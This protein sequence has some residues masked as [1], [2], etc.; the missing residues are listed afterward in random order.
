MSVI[1]VNNLSKSYR[2]Y[3]SRWAR[4]MEWVIPFTGKLHKEK[5]VLKNISFKIE[6]GESVGVIGINGAGKST[7]LKII[8]GIMRPTAGEIRHDGR[9]S[10]ILELGMGFHPDFTGRQ[11]V[12][13]A[14]QL[15]GLEIKELD[16]LLPEIVEFSEIGSYIDQPVRVYSSGMQVRL[17]FGVATAK[18]PGILIVDEAFSVGDVAFQRKCFRRIEEFRKQGTTL[19]LVSH[20]IA[21]IRKICKKALYIKDGCLAEFGDSRSVC[22]AYEKQL[23]SSGKENV[24]LGKNDIVNEI[25]DTSIEHERHPETGYGDG[26]AIIENVWLVAAEGK[27]T[28][29]LYQSESVFRVGLGVFFR[30]DIEDVVFSIMIKTREGLPIY[31]TDTY[32][33]KRSVLKFRRDDRIQVSFVLKNCLAP[34]IYYLNCAVREGEGGGTIFVHRKIDTLIFRVMPDEHTTSGSGMVD[35]RAEVQISE[36]QDD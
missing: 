17:A 32:L 6:S 28:N 19:L 5:W 4:L 13:I 35:M 16:R 10:A 24:L 1:I 21:T 27:L 15:L 22:D 33:V 11:N 20:D 14:G 23:F 18:R 9:V 29:I 36:L 30:E 25:I 34:G 3:P 2:V 8:C 7:L 31:G 12:Y 26:R